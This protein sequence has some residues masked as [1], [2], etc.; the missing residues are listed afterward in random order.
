MPRTKEHTRAHR[1]IQWNRVHNRNT[2]K[3][4]KGLK[5]TEEKM[6]VPIACLWRVD[7][8]VLCFLSIVRKTC[9]E[10]ISAELFS[11]M[12]CTVH[13]HTERGRKGETLIYLAIV[14]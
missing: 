13:G 6:Y 8:C 4:W 12:Q 1:Q 2:V 14:N 3:H 11:A 5:A 7:L 9:H 10:H